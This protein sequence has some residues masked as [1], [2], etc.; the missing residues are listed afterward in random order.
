[1][2]RIV[3]VYLMNSP[4]NISRFVC[5]KSKPNPFQN[6]LRQV[7]NT[8]RYAPMNNVAIYFWILNRSSE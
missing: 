7:I 6:N 4:A 5:E 8:L 1:M 2:H 3:H